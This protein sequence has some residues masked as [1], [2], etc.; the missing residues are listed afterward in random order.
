[1]VKLLH[2]VR[3]DPLK[4][5]AEGAAQEEDLYGVGQVPKEQRAKN[6]ST[7]IDGQVGT[8]EKATVGK[9]AVN[10]CAV[11]AL[12]HIANHAVNEEEQPREIYARRDDHGRLSFTLRYVA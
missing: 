2:G 11:G 6:G 12:D 5:A 1:M 4:R 9:V 10:D 8:I 3:G 7:A